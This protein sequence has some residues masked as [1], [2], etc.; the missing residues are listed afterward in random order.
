LEIRIQIGGFMYLVTAEFIKEHPD[1]III[2]CRY[3]MSNPPFGYDEYCN[4]HI[5]GAYYMDLDKDMTS[6]LQTHGGRHPLADLLTFTD[7]LG[8]FGIKNDSTVVI[9]D[10]GELAMASRLWFMCQLIGLNTYIVE[11]GYNAL[12]DIL[13]VSKEIPEERVSELKMHYDASII[14]N[15]DDVIGAMKKEKTV[16]VDSRSNPRYLGL[17]E[18]F[19]KIAGHIPTAVNYFWKD[20]FKDDQVKDY[21]DIEAMFLEMHHYDDIIVHCGSGITGCVNMFF[22]N[23]INIKSKLYA[24]SYSD[25]LSYDDNE[26][27][28]KDN[29]RQKVKFI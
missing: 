8:S 19:D 24:G 12:K 20:N 21:G 13:E 2:D 4:G 7:K 18:P 14:C 16:I 25:W 3:D 5:K 28:I 27:I 6:E 9:Y 11:G 23:E 10:N 26:V 22:L 29:K 15:K 1:S 17:E